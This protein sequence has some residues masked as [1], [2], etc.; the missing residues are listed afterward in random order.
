VWIF[1]VLVLLVTLFAWSLLRGVPDL[2]TLVTA[3]LIYGCTLLVITSVGNVL[4]VLFPIRRDI[5]SMTNSPSQAAMLIGFASLL[6][7]VSLESLFL[8]PGALLGQ[9]FLQPLALSLLLAVLAWAYSVALRFAARMMDR[10]KDKLVES[11]RPNA[12]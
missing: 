9:R 1:N 12:S 7:A 3:V 8:L 6:F 11:L 10:R 4:S 2:L 5:S